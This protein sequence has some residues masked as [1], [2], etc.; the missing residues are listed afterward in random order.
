[1]GESGW[2]ELPGVFAMERVSE[3]R[4]FLWF[5]H[6]LVLH[7][8]PQ[9]SG[10]HLPVC[11]VRITNS[12]LARSNISPVISFKQWIFY[13]ERD[14]SFPELYLIIKCNEC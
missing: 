1:M 2:N 14:E 4:C 12:C 10:A 13:F 11:Q 8:Y 3:E 5:P 7:H 6:L 9:H